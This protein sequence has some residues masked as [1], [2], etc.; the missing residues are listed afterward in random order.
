MSLQ[1]FLLSL[2]ANFLK[3]IRP[4]GLLIITAIFLEKWEPEIILV[5][6]VKYYRE[7]QINFLFNLIDAS[8]VKGRRKGRVNPEDKKEAEGKKEKSVLTNSLHESVM[9]LRAESL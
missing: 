2:S 5:C 7:T 1:I 6:S 9:R 4:G 3:V 8:R